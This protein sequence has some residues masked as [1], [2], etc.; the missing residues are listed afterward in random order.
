MYT[1][2]QNYTQNLRSKDE[3]LTTRK[4]KQVQ[5]VKDST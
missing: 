4:I 1:H 5:E 3:N 2:F